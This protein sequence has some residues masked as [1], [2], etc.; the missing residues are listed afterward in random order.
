MASGGSFSQ[1]WLS[2]VSTYPIIGILGIAVSG[3]CGFMAYKFAYHPDIRVTK[4]TKG[5]VIRT[6]GQEW[7][8]NGKFA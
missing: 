6:W 4:N 1:N 2:D 8:L 7:T 5:E 3:C